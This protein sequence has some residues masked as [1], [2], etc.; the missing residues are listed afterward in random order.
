MNRNTVHKY[1]YIGATNYLETLEKLRDI[2][3]EYHDDDA[4]KYYDCKIREVEH[5]IIFIKKI[6]KYIEV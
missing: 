2:S 5:D 6:T 3:E 4:V 1:A